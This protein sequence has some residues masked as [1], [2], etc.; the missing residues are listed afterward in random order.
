MTALA[1]RLASLANVRALLGLVLVL[2]TLGMQAGGGTLA[3]FTSTVSSNGNTFTA[4]ELVLEL[5]DTAGPSTASVVFDPATTTALAPAQFRDAILKVETV[6]P[7]AVAASVA[8]T[9]LRTQGSDGTKA[10][11]LDGRLQFQLKDVTSAAVTTSAG[12]TSVDYSTGATTLTTPSAA[13]TATSNRSLIPTSATE[14]FPAVSYAAGGATKY[15]CLRIKWV[16]GTGTTVT[17]LDNAAQG[18]SNTYT[19]TFTATST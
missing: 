8:S 10:N 6:T 19:L 15:Y 16:D 4:G 14:F 7:N 11:A 17:G 12:C 13:P 5:N 3:F 1:A 2:G 18:G 9:I